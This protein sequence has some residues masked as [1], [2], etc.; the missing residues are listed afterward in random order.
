MLG[1]FVLQKMTDVSSLSKD[2]EQF[3]LET[4]KYWFNYSFAKE[5]KR[6]W[7]PRELNLVSAFL[8]GTRR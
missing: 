2:K 1:I 8:Q 4:S 3:I 5:G 6:G 7:V